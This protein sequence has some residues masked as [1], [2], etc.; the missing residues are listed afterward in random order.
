MRTEL[1]N[2]RA[3]LTTATENANKTE[4]QMK[5]LE[6]SVLAKDKEL[7]SLTGFGWYC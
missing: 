3:A 4:E 7:E 2:V 1:E 6:T 5:Q